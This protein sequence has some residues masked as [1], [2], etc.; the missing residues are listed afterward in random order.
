MSNKPPE[1]VCV[2][3][4]LTEFEAMLARN[5]LVEAGIQAM[6]V[7]A[8]TANFRAETPGVVKVLVPGNAE[9]EA[10]KLM[11]EFDTPPEDHD[12]SDQDPDASE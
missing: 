1:P 3:Q 4:Y 2:G 9:E 6:V 8:M 10:L 5:M 11:I 7:G 12:L